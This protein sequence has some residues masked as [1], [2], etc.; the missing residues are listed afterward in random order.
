M[1]SEVLCCPCNHA[2]PWCHTVPPRVHFYI[3]E[4]QREVEPLEGSL[5]KCNLESWND[6][7]TGI[8]SCI[9]TFKIT[10][11]HSVSCKSSLRACRHHGNI[12]FYSHAREL[13]ESTSLNW[14]SQSL[15]HKRNIQSIVNYLPGVNSLMY[16]YIINLGE[17]N[18]Y[19]K[20]GFNCVPCSLLSTH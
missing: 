11:L 4:A 15:Y 6:I 8:N 19:S 18:D 5:H 10:W 2:Q 17:Y 20:C 13:R 3:T 9:N 16:N 1:R 7:L 12:I 14:R